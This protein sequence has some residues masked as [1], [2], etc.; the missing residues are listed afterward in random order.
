MTLILK[1]WLAEKSTGFSGAK[2]EQAIVFS[3]YSALAQKTTITE[4]HSFEELVKIRPLSIVMAEKL[5]RSDAG[6]KTGWSAQI[7]AANQ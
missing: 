4:T 1:H 5:N 3:I 7:N 6:H 2:I